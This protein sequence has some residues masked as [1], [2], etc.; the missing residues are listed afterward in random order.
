[1]YTAVKPKAEIPAQ[2]ITSNSAPT[3]RRRLKKSKDRVSRDVNSRI[4]TVLNEK[5]ASFLVPGMEL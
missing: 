5:I 3:Q 1:M 4:P 2:V